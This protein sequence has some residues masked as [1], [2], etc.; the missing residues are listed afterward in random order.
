MKQKWLRWWHNYTWKHDN[1]RFE[2]YT[3]PYHRQISYHDAAPH[4]H[5]CSCGKELGRYFHIV[6][7][8]GNGESNWFAEYQAE[9]GSSS[10]YGPPL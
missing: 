3:Y 7:K 1:L 4:I 10:L 2:T 5:Y 8:W 6:R 9:H